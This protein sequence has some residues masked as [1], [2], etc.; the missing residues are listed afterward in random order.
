MS[1]TPSRL[2]PLALLGLAVS[3][4]AWAVGPPVPA[5]RPAPDEAVAD[6]VPLRRVLLTPDRLPAALN[7][8][9]DGVLTRLPRDE[10]ESLVRRA[11]LAAAAGRSGP[12]LVEARYRARLTDAGALAGT[13]GWKLHNPGGGPALFR[14]GPDNG[15]LTLALRKP[16]FGDR[17]A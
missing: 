10:F 15:P 4:A 2:A 1:L 14:L 9:K 5:E 13:A 3:L 17:D 8:V 6:P 16:R 7:R 11:G 12:R